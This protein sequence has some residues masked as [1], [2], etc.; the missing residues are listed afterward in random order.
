[1][2]IA[3]INI[4]HSLSLE[5]LFDSCVEQLQ[6][7]RGDVAY[8]PT[9]LHEDNVVQ[10][11]GVIAYL[12]GFCEPDRGPQRYVSKGLYAITEAIYTYDAY[13]A[14]SGGMLLL[15]WVSFPVAADGMAKMTGR[16]HWVNHG[17]H[18]VPVVPE[19][20][21]DVRKQSSSCAQMR[22]RLLPRVGSV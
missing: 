4:I 6:R 15:C 7:H 10:C 3:S 17:T 14:D 11:A 21:V 19:G 8:A 1:M 12:V 22:P 9:W 20:P 5:V 13:A 2:S 18:F 16:S